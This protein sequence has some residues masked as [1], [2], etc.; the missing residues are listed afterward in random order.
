M[1][2]IP[3]SSPSLVSA[4]R[5]GIGIVSNSPLSASAMP[6]S[7]SSGSIVA[8]KPIVPKFTANTGTSRRA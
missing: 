4:T 3:I 1:S 2:L 7:R 5:P 6:V 8:R